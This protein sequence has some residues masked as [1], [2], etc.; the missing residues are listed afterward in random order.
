MEENYYS[1]IAIF[2]IS[3]KSKPVTLF[4]VYLFFSLTSIIMFYSQ[5]SFP[6]HLICQMI[7][8][9]TEEIKIFKNSILLI[10]LLFLYN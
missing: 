4:C 5:N 1:T 9:A 3:M 8:G 10:E 6:D 7:N 2:L